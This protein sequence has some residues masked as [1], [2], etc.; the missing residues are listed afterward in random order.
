MHGLIFTSEG[1]IQ[2]DELRAAI[3]GIA[4]MNFAISGFSLFWHHIHTLQK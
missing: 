1:G 4:T 2:R 3:I